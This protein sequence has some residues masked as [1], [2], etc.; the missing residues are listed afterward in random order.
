MGRGEPCRAE[1]Q[2]LRAEEAAEPRHPDDVRGQG[3]R[4][5]ARSG[6]VREGHALGRGLAVRRGHGRRGRRAARGGH[7]V[8]DPGP[9]RA[10]RRERGHARGARPHAR[11]LH[12]GVRAGARR[13]RRV[14]G[15][16]GPLPPG[17]RHRHDAHRRA[18]PGRRGAAPHHRLPPRAGVRGHLHALRDRRPSRRLGLRAAAQPLPRDRRRAAGRRPG[19]G[20]GALR[21]HA[22]HDPAPR[23]SLRHVS[24]GHRP[25]WPA[26]GRRHARLRGPRAGHERA[27]AR[28][29]RAL[30][31]RR[32]RRGLRPHV[33]RAQAEHPDRHGAH[34]LRGRPRARALQQDGRAR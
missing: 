6:A 1:A 19:D 12:G 2:H 34:R 31:Q 29:A 21:Q 18:P 23:V 7:R 25:L 26:P 5:R 8:A 15:A 17:R 28:G 3:G 11:G 13:G 4:L 32:R 33:P 24:R 30:P 9:L 10:P 16:R 20:P 14:G 22:G 27:R